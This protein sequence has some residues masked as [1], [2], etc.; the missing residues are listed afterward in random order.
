MFARL[1]AKEPL[2]RQTPRPAA[3]EGEQV[4]G[5]LA[6]ALAPALGC[7]FVETVEDEGEDAEEGVDDDDQDG[8]LEVES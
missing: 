8:G 7:E 6:D 4:Q 1:V 3:A 5:A 2:P